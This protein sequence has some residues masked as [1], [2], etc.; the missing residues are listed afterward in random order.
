MR[1]EPD[2]EHYVPVC[3]CPGCGEKEDLERSRFIRWPVEEEP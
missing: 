3:D 1:K 2:D